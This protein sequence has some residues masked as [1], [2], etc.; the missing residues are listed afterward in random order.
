MKHPMGIAAVLGLFLAGIGCAP[1]KFVKV[2]TTRPPAPVKQAPLAA[3]CVVNTFHVDEEVPLTFSSNFSFAEIEYDEDLGAAL[4]RETRGYLARSGLFRQILAPGGA[5][6]EVRYE[7]S[8]H[9]RKFEWSERTGVIPGA[10]LSGATAGLY[11][12]CGFPV[13]WPEA[14]VEI[15]FAVKPL[16]GGRTKKYYT[17]V[18]YK[19]WVSIYG[20]ERDTPN[21]QLMEAFTRALEDLIVQVEKDPPRIIKKKERT[22]VPRTAPSITLLAPDSEVTAKNRIQVIAHVSG[23]EEL[24]DIGLWV[25]DRLIR[26]VRPENKR[27]EKVE[28]TVSLTKGKNTIRLLARNRWGKK[29]EKIF[30]IRFRPLLRQ[31]DWWAMFTF[32]GDVGALEWKN[33]TQM[34][35]LIALYNFL[36]SGNRKGWGKE[37]NRL[38]IGKRATHKNLFAGLF[39][40]LKKPSSKNPALIAFSGPVAAPESALSKSHL[41]VT[42]SRLKPKAASTISFAVLKKALQRYIRSDNVLVLL[43]LARFEK[44][45]GNLDKA[46]AGLVENRNGLVIVALVQKEKSGNMSLFKSA[47]SGLKG[48]ADADGDGVI[49]VRELVNFLEKA[50]PATAKASGALKVYGEVRENIAVVGGKEGVNVDPEK[51]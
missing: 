7:L 24:F 16:P 41:L 15:E 23:K 44:E 43:E 17:E 8:G 45:K 26:M 46:L 10:L 14:S 38:I 22:P 5:L 29:T 6:P 49:V 42:D 25:N 27:S 3:P 9:V 4:A 1:G 21:V 12:L 34:N 19:D 40:F 48:K 35:D 51:R 47:L 13:N 36:S 2:A 28:E 11:A 50:F 31:P 20:A 32:V 37:R 18:Q 33:K 30:E 39:T